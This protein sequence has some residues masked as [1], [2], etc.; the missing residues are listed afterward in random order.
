MYCCVCLLFF[1]FCFVVACCLFEFVCYLIV[2]S[3]VFGFPVAWFASHGAQPCVA[4]FV[5]LV[6]CWFVL[7]ACCGCVFVS[8]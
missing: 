3:C 2:L 5:C 1:L 6:A 7:R 4:V 8:V